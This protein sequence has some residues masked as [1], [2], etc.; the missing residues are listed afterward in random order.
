MD[1][2]MFRKPVR[3]TFITVLCVLTFVGSGYSLVSSIITMQL[4]GKFEQLNEQAVNKEIKSSGTEKGNEFAEKMINDSKEMLKKENVIKLNIGNIVANLLTLAGAILMFRMNK[5]GFWLYLA[6]IIIWIGTPL[7]LFGVNSVPG[8]ISAV[9]QG[10]VGVLFV[11]MY[12][13]N[14]KEMN[15]VP[16]ET[17]LL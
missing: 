14:L 9:G 15:P 12:A 16:V 6:G 5:R 13:F 1:N 7:A 8:I 11:V 3:T 2:I 10:I 17:D 4:A